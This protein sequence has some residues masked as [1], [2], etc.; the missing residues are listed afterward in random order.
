ML[1]AAVLVSAV[2]FASGDVLSWDGFTYKKSVTFHSPGHMPD[3]KTIRA[4]QSK[5]GYQGQQLLGW[6][7]D[8]DQYAGRSDVTE[9]SYRDLVNGESVAYLADQY[10]FAVTSDLQAA[11]LAVA[12]WEVMNET[13]EDVFHAGSGNFSVAE[14]DVVAQANAYLATVPESYTP[15][16]A[17]LVLLSETK[18][19][20]LVPNVGQVPEPSTMS[21][22]ALGGLAVLRRR[23]RR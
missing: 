12:I 11:G 6:C 21:L 4:G 15:M 16:M 8:I 3:G 5:L 14:A 20:F 17:P 10:A 22:L 2:G 9:G 7:I 13:Q 23:L 19:D 18:Q 1:M